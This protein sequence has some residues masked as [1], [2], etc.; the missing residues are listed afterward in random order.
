MMI[1][2]R[3]PK[4]P[5]IGEHGGRARAD[6]LQ[7]GKRSVRIWWSK[8]GASSRSRARARFGRRYSWVST[9]LTHGRAF[10]LGSHSRFPKEHSVIRTSVLAI[11]AASAVGCTADVHANVPQPPEVHA[12]VQVNAPPPPQANVEVQTTGAAAQV[13][14]QA[15]PPPQAQVTVVAPPPP[16]VELSVEA[17]TPPPPPAIRVE[18]V[19]A[20]PGAEFVWIGGYHRWNGSTYVWVP[21]RHERRPHARA[22][23]RPARWEQRGR[24][25]VWIEGRFE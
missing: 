13:Q 7:R 16:Q 24:R 1:A 20:S 8:S 25:H 22:V 2:A 17:A 18:V 4:L 5:V 12:D 10:R 23:W 6:Q 3:H 15:P 11:L 9:R 19:P 21:G 14:V